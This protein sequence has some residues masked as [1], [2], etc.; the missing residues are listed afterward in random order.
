MVREFD[1]DPAAT[2]SDARIAPPDLPTKS[3]NQILVQARAESNADIPSVSFKLQ[4]RLT[5]CSE[6]SRTKNRPQT[7]IPEQHLEPSEHDGLRQK[8]ALAR[9]DDPEEVTRRIADYRGTTKRDPKT[10]TP[11]TAVRPRRL[12]HNWQPEP[13]NPGGFRGYQSPEHRRW[14]SIIQGF[15][16]VQGFSTS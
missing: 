16:N 8:R 4:N 10:T 14:H 7:I 11:D 5:G 15:Q 9:G 12:K 3:Y 13:D 2:D 6:T 1:G